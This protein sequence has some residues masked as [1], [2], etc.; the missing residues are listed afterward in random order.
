LNGEAAGDEF[1]ESVALSSDGSR[2][3]IG[4]PSNG[5]NGVEADQAGHVRIYDWRGSQWTQV[6][7]DLDGEATGDWFGWSVALSSDGNRVAIGGYGSDSNTGHVRV[8]DWTGGEWMQVGS[9]LNG[10]GADDW[11]GRSVALSSDGTRVAIGA[12]TDGNSRNAGYVR[13]YDI[14]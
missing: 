14:T 6:G 9:N 8:F 3:A 10:N 7:S 11:F 5:G 12:P 4:A 1:G 2:V 13:A